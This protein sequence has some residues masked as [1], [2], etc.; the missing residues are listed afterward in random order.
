MKEDYTRFIKVCCNKFLDAKDQYFDVPTKE[1]YDDFRG[2]VNKCLDMINKKIEILEKEKKTPNKEC[3]ITVEDSLHNAYCRYFTFSENAKCQY[4]LYRDLEDIAINY[5]KKLLE[6][7][8][9]VLT[10]GQLRYPDDIKE[11]I[12]LNFR[13]GN[14]FRVFDE[15][16][17]V[18]KVDIDTVFFEPMKE[19]K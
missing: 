9:K 5:P 1:E 3:R 8:N 7:W 15:D 10:K 11:E 18:S 6:I 16:Y 13:R 12:Y 19:E 14:V 4:E 17:V 2:R